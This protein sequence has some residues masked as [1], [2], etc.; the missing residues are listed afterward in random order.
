M[1]RA[2][3]Q[4]QDGEGDGDAQHQAQS[5]D[6]SAFQTVDEHED[7]DDDHHR[8]QKVDHESADGSVHLVGLEEDFLGAEAYR[9]TLHDFRQFLIDCGSHVGYHHTG[10]RGQADAQSRF[11]VD[12][13]TTCL[14]FLVFTFDGSDVAQAHL[15]TAGGI[16]EHVGHVLLVLKFTADAQLDAF[17]DVERS[18][19][20]GLLSGSPLVVGH[21]L[22]L[23]VF[24]GVDGHARIQQAHHHFGWDDAVAC[25]FVFRQDDVDDFGACP[26]NID[27][28]HAW[29]GE[30]FTPYQ[31]G[32]F[33]QFTVGITVACESVEQSIHIEHVVDDDGRE[34]S[35]REFG[36]GI[37][38]LS[39]QEVEMLL[40][41]FH[42]HC[43]EEL[44][45]DESL[46]GL[47]LRL[48]VFH[49]GYGTKFVLHHLHG[50]QL[51]LVCCTA[52]PY[53]HH[54]CL[55]HGHSRVFQFG[56]AQETEHA[57]EDDADDET[58][59]D[60]GFFDE[61]FSYR[62]CF[63][64]RSPTLVDSLVTILTSSPSCR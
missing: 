58:P 23:V 60:D 36:T 7:D 41:L 63:H 38:S 1:Q 49:I 40:H 35:R 19:V 8:F 45:G 29:H 64:S 21:I 44:Y 43:S 11:P 25:Q 30:Q 62:S 22:G 16:D 6:T 46:S 61:K 2:V 14:R 53:Q 33:L 31:F 5:D 26:D 34:A 57:Y 27:A 17:E 4:K 55:L 56:H 37:P 3:E 59:E 42:L 32:V 15:F 52:R 47:A 10:I 50:F 51:H 13:E 39:S 9:H 24:T 12:E 20:C 28:F 18:L 54:L 48:D